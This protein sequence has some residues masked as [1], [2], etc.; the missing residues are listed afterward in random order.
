MRKTLVL[1]NSAAA[2]LFALSATAHA[3]DNI[4]CA[5][6]ALS[7]GPEYMLIGYENLLAF[8]DPKQPFSKSGSSGDLAGAID[9]CAEENGWSK[10]ASAQASRYTIGSATSDYIG[11]QMAIANAPEDFGKK[12]Y[13]D[14]SAA[15]LKS[16]R[17]TGKFSSV[18]TALIASTMKKYFG[19]KPKKGV[20]DY[21]YR[22]PQ[23][24]EDRDS[25]ALKFLQLPK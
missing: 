14:M 20:K 2:A 25:A 10:E 11:V 12:L 7:E 18:H 4:D 5:K 13:N 9:S 23:M 15:E 21:F 16:L 8:G 19:S 22:W 3:A 6:D 17:K 24:L 1:L